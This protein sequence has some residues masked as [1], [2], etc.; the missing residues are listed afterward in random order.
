MQIISSFRD[1]KT[2]VNKW[3]SSKFAPSENPLHFVFYFYKVIFA[4]FKNMGFFQLVGSNILVFFMNRLLKVIFFQEWNSFARDIAS[5]VQWNRTTSVY[6]LTK[7]SYCI[8]MRWHPLR[9]V[10]G[11]GGTNSF[12]FFQSSVSCGRILPRLTDESSLVSVSITLLLVT[13]WM[14]CKQVAHHKPPHLLLANYLI[15]DYIYLC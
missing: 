6:V 15:S 9:F 10:G 4:S 7:T 8:L 5:H 2:D 12:S 14:V 11:R 1:G 13:Y 3:L